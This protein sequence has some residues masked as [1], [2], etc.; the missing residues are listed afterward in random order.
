MNVYHFI[1]F[2][3]TRNVFVVPKLRQSVNPG[4][5][6]SFAGVW[7]K[8]EYIQQFNNHYEYTVQTPAR[9]NDRTC[10]HA[11]WRLYIDNN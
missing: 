3:K 8:H 11:C 5:D 2:L 1:D 4:S 6:P 7:T 9:N 10:L